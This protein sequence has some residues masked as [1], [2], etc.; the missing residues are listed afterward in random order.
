M[1]RTL[2]AGPVAGATARQPCCSDGPCGR[3]WPEADRLAAAIFIA[4]VAWAARR[5]LGDDGCAPA[6]CGLV[7]CVVA[8]GAV[9]LARL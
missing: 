1:A 6:A 2:L 9:G 8:A 3:P 5:R 7:F 4:P